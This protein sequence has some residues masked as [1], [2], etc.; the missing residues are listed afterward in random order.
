MHGGLR[1]A[2]DSAVSFARRH[3][4]RARELAGHLDRGVGA[5]LRIY[6]QVA[7]ILA[8]HARRAL[9]DSADRI[10]SNVLHGARFYGEQKRRLMQAD[11]MSRAIARAV[12]KEL[13]GSLA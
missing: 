11:H 6:H 8:P 4:G 10:H 7:P 12:H 13:N 1:G 5:A 9:G 2:Y 3:Y